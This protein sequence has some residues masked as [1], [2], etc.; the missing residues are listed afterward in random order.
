MAEPTRAL[1]H[2]KRALSSS[3][4]PCKTVA[5]SDTKKETVMS[6]PRHAV[7]IPLDRHRKPTRGDHRHYRLFPPMTD[8]EGGELDY[9]IV[10]ATIVYRP[11][12]FVFAADALGEITS[13]SELPGSFV[14]ALDHEEALR[15]AGYEVVVGVNPVAMASLEGIA[16]RT[17]IV[18]TLS[19]Q[20]YALW[21]GALDVP[22]EVVSEELPA[23]P[24]AIEEGK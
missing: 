9:V 7:E 1:K 21:R 15:G 14:G 16:P 5:L 4:H 17:D 8:W 13:F 2:G 22:F 10:S 20:A 6:T 24:L 19:R 11:E 12:T 23:A 18:D 3:Y